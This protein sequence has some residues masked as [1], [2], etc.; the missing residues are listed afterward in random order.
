M[1][2]KW[3]ETDKLD[4]AIKP[5]D[6]K[7]YVENYG[8]YITKYCQNCCLSSSTTPCFLCGL[9]CY[10]LSESY[11]SSPKRNQYFD[12][13]NWYQREHDHDDAFRSQD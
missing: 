4:Y 7:H 12:D 9:R 2:K 13:D 11:Y 8:N 6:I 3:I 1:K 5:S 10:N